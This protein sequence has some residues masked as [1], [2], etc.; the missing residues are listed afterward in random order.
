MRSWQREDYF[1]WEISAAAHS[2]FDDDGFLT[3]QIVP[4]G[5]KDGSAIPCEAHFTLGIISRPHDPDVDGNGSPTLGAN[6][7]FAHEGNRGHA[8]LLSD[9]RCTGRLPAVTKGSFCA[10]SFA[11]PTSKAPTMI[12]MDASK[13]GTLQ[14]YVP[15]G[16]T[17]STLAFDVSTA[18]SENIQLRHGLGMGLLIGAGGGNP[19]VLNNKAGDA[20]V[21]LNDD[22][23]SVG[24]KTITLQGGVNLGDAISAQ[25]LVLGP[26][27]VIALTSLIAATAQLATLL[28]QCISPGQLPGNAAATAIAGQLAAITGTLAACLAQKSKAT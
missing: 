1:D 18:G 8:W 17:A 26:P 19:V 22:G 9:P 4:N 15:H 14:V 28:G 24:A 3:I 5:G 27:L 11:T 21:V 6:V 20:T 16:D 2:D 23:I 13:N 7:L 12:H 10:Y 25:P